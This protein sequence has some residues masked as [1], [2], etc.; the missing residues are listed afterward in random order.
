MTF[1]TRNVVRLSARLDAGDQHLRAD[2]TVPSSSTLAELLPEFLLLLDAPDSPQPWE[3]T[4]AAGHPLEQHVP[5]HELELYDGHV[6]VIRPE[7]SDSAP[8]VRDAAESLAAF[9]P[10]AREVRG[11]GTAAAVCG[12]LGI[13]ILAASFIPTPVALLC[14][15][16]GAVLLAL[17]TRTESLAALGVVAAALAA[18]WWVAGPENS[19]EVAPSAWGAG[20]AAGA[21]VAGV[22]VAGG[23]YTRLMGAR[24][25]AALG[26]AAAIVGGGSIGAWLPGEAAMG[27]VS[28]LIAL[29]AVTI[30]PGMATRISGLRI[31]RVPTAGEDLPDAFDYQTDVDARAGRAHRLTEGFMVGVAGGLIPAFVQLAMVGGEW[32]WALLVCTAGALVVHGSRLHFPVPRAAALFTVLAALVAAATAVATSDIH[33]AVVVLAF[34]ITC[35]V[36]TTPLWSPYVSGLEPTTVVWLE[37]AEQAAIIAAIPLAMQVAGIFLLIRGL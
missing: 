25:G 27:A 23:V 9:A 16:V 2:C 28:V 34:A 8:V 21:V 1:A 35:G 3:F 22:L 31:P 24:A 10:G 33:I 15:A 5:L 12:L 26:A 29:L 32:V 6:V 19:P 13:V 20:I 4:T 37:R 11:L 18:G 17:F 14:G 7:I 36:G 30:A